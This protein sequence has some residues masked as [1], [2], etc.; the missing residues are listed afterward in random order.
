MAKNNK[1]AAAKALRAAIEASDMT[2]YELAKRS[3]VDK[4][5]IGRF[6]AG[7]RDLVFER[8]GQLFEI[9][10]LELRPTKKPKP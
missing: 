6:M 3:G 4:S 5:A 7:E 8:A 1:T 9:L 2:V 10:G